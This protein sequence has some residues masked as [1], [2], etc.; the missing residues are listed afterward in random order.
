[1]WANVIGFNVGIGKYMSGLTSRKNANPRE[2][3]STPTITYKYRFTSESM[4][5]YEDPP[6]KWNH[7][8]L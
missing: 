8:N 2:H 3:E 6:V 4:I 7:L 1:M 5:K